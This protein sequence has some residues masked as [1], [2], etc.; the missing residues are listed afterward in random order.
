MS[1][2]VVSWCRA[3]PVTLLIKA[4]LS[5]VSGS[6]SLSADFSPHVAARA[7]PAFYTMSHHFLSKAHCGFTFCFNFV[8]VLVFA[9]LS[10]PLFFFYFS[11]ISRE[12]ERGKHQL[13][14]ERHHT[15][16]I[17]PQPNVGT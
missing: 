1:H 13:I 2:Y 9:L 8:H 3:E 15:G 17:Q 12:G 7:A 6:F 5:R 11:I 14:H 10:S 16:G 4:S